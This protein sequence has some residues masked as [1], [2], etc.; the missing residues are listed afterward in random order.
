MKHAF[1]ALLIAT[2][3]LLAGCDTPEG[4][5]ADYL[6]KAQ[7]AYDAGDLVKARIDAQNAVQ[8]QPKNS[9]ARYLL[10]LL[11][12]RDGDVRQQV[13]HLTVVVDTDPGNVEA[14]LKLGMLYFVGQAWDRAAE[15]VDEL[16]KLAPDNIQVRLLHARVLIQKGDRQA[17]LAEI[18]EALRAEPGNV[19]AILLSAA[20]AAVANLDEGLLILDEAI[21]KIGEDKARALRELR[22]VLLVQGERTKDLE[23][24]LLGLIADYPSHPTYKTQLASVY[25]QEGRLDE[26]EVLLRQVAMADKTDVANRLRYAQFLANGKDPLKAETA[27]QMFIGQT[28]EAG[29]LRLALGQFYEAAGRV[30]DARETYEALAKKGPKT[31][32]GLFART[33]LA[34][35]DIRANQ[36]AAGMTRVDAVLVDAPDYPAAL[37][38][39]AGNRLQ[40]GRNNDAIADLRNVLRSE[41]GNQQAL[42]LLAQTYARTGEAALAQ[43]TYRRLLE[44]NPNSG[45][46]VAQ[47]ASLF[48][49][50]KNYS[51][52]EN[53]L[54]RRIEAFPNDI[55]ASGRLVDVLLLQEKTAEAEA[56]AQRLA[57]LTNQTGAG[58]FVLGRVLASRKNYAGAAE[59]YRRS[60]IG[61]DDP[62]ALEALVQTLEAAGKSR[63]AIEVLLDQVRRDKNVAMSHLLL[64]GL[65]GRLG[66]KA[67][68]AQHVEQVLAAKRDLP[69]AYVVLAGVYRDDTQSRIKALRRG[70]EAVP[71]DV[72]LSL[73]LAST[74]ESNKQVDDA[75][76]VYE[77]L[78]KRQ[79]EF[80]LANNNLAALLLDHRT[81]DPASMA[82]A[83]TLAEKLT[84]SE[85]P[86]VRDTLGWAYYRNKEFRKA[87]GILESVVAESP[88]ASLFRYH[89]GMTYLA[90]DD[91]ESARRELQAALESRNDFVGRNEAEA[92]LAEI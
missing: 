7:K 14:R 35:M 85:N 53:I 55:I 50:D 62:A 69:Y 16:V 65:H 28:P 6:E 51:E 2:S 74:L 91:P 12:E 34:V 49:A 19:D 80:E 43:D 40:N 57:M 45:E 59:A 86:I 70:L 22:T 25:E 27:L 83:L 48:A 72:P 84:S 60:T 67:V 37:L 47:I 54:R 18:Q 64:A 66:E 10:A 5:A 9:K 42:Q 4:R 24:D 71:G 77:D 52:A 76:Q 20:A 90:L 82:R 44:V 39:R 61:T 8:V 11:A 46:A 79:P 17:G 81:K 38:L 21:P 41:A 13:G 89:L 3:L 78:L 15:Q 75:I 73:L 33:A 1:P 30:D 56:E 88:K 63:Q 31:S 32:D 58:A 23:K 29:A 68:A 36:V 26:A 92:A 87:V